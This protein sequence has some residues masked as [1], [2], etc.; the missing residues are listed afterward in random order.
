M[1]KF[2]EN[3]IKE[4]LNN[5]QFVEWVINPT[6]DLELYWTNIMEKEP[7]KKKEI[8]ALRRMI[9]NLRVEEPSLTLQDKEMLWQNILEGRKEKKRTFYST[10]W[11]KV[12]SVAAVIIIA[13]LGS[14]IFI[15]G[16]ADDIN[17]DYNQ[18]VSQIKGL[19]KSKEIYLILADNR[20]VDIDSGSEVIFD[21]KG[22]LIANSQ[23][24]NLNEISEDGALNHL[25]VPNG[26]TAEV[27][28]SDGTRVAVN[29]G[30]H[31]VFPSLFGSKKREIY[32]DGEIFLKVTKN[33]ECPFIVKTDKMD[34]K[35]LGTSFN[36][37]A[38][39]NETKQSVVL[40]MGSVAV[41]NKVSNGECKIVPNQM[42]S[43]EN[44]TDEMNVKRVDVYD[45]ICW[46]Y[47]FLHLKSEKLSSVLAKLQRYYDMKIEFDAAAV[48]NIRVSGKLDLKE[49]IQHVLKVISVTA[50]IQYQIQQNSLS[51]KVKP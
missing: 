5:D 18:V 9:K 45:Y 14:F 3:R 41:K 34:V 44:T 16:D 48:D 13:F 2:N 33:A 23:K 6:T 22:N 1:D 29:S 49:D 31:L 12:S 38:Y 20:R 24:F 36:V 30:S 4:L 46:Q 43:Y 11:F 10:L 40:V 19:R 17:I 35:V 15:N 8:T 50:P 26:K 32:V 39:K 21:K 42:Y 7:Y 28:L 51:I 25:V 27:K 47:G 37:S